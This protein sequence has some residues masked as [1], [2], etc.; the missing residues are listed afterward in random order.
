MDLQ[1]D[2]LSSTPRFLAVQHSVRV[3][4]QRW[5]ETLIARKL[6]ADFLRFRKFVLYIQALWRG[7]RVRDSIQKVLVLFVG[8]N[9]YYKV[10]ANIILSLR[11]SRV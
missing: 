10:I 3:I 6:H 1:H 11:G 2:H 8:I 5:R 7:Q 9:I 4:Q